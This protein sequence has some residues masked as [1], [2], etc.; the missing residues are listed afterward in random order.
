M[1]QVPLRYGVAAR[2]SRSAVWDR[3]DAALLR[4]APPPVQGAQGAQPQPVW[5]PLYTDGC[6]ARFRF[7]ISSRSVCASFDEEQR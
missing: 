4:G 3:G 6:V 1:T 2:G 5:Y 7:A